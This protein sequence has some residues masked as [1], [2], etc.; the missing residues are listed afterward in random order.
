MTTQMEHW[1]GTCPNNA[2]L[3]EFEIQSKFGMLWFKICPTNH[4]EILHMSWQLHCHD[5]CKFCCDPTEYVVDKSNTMFHWISN[6]IT[7]II[8]GTHARP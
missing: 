4:K 5:M 7:N 1:Q 2:I 6:L 8:C 3:I